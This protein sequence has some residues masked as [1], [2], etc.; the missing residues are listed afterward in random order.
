MYRLY[1]IISLLIFGCNTTKTIVMT[2]PYPIENKNSQNMHV[3]FVKKSFKNKIG[4]VQSEFE[5]YYV[6]MSVQDYFV[7][8]CDSNVSL[9]E[10]EKRLNTQ[11]GL[12][13]TL[14][15]ELEIRDGLW[16]ACDT[17]E[18]VQSRTGKYVVITKL[19]SK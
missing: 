13:K 6:R 9:E 17:N 8:W 19:I 1:F 15:V 18:M 4:K 12:I 14:E 7:K 16:D 5:E 3:E 2:L 10:V 11:S